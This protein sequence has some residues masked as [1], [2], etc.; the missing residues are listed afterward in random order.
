MTVSTIA[1]NFEAGF[2]LATI[3]YEGALT[4]VSEGYTPSGAKETF[5]SRAAGLQKDQIVMLSADSGNT[6]SAT[7]GM[8]VATT[9][10]A[11]TAKIIGKIVSEPQWVKVP[12]ASQ[13]TWATMLAGKYYRVATVEW[14]GVTDVVPATLTDSGENAIEPGAVGTLKLDASALAADPDGGIQVSDAAS[15]GTGVFSFHYSNTAGTYTVLLGFT[16]G[17]IVIQA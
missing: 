2:P 5:V 16:G 3:L 17:G 12:T 4:L 9:F 8:P 7:D 6:F 1:S 14:Y 11:G 15:G 10:A 13:D